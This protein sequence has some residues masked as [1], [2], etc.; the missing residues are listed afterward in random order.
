MLPSTLSMG[1][2]EACLALAWLALACL[3]LACL[4]LSW[5]WFLVKGL[6]IMYNVEAW[7]FLIEGQNIRQAEP[8][9]D[10]K[11][12]PLSVIEPTFPVSLPAPENC[13]LMENFLE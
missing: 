10:P 3:A 1:M 11:V 2:G 4:A 13:A 5:L 6:V 9:G 7:R 12:M 8:E